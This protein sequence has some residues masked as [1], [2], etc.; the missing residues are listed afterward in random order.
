M[1]AERLHGVLTGHE[2]KTPR[3]GITA[4]HKTMQT[5]LLCSAVACAAL[6]SQ[7]ASARWENLYDTDTL[8][9]ASKLY[10]KN[11]Q[12]T[13]TEDFLAK[14]LP[15]DRQAI[16]NV[17]LL[18]PLVGEHAHPFDYYAY[19]SRK[20]VVV[21]IQSVKFLDDLAIAHTWLLNRN[22]SDQAVFDYVGFLRFGNIKNMPGGRLPT[23]SAALRVP[24]DAL[25]NTWVN[26]VSGKILKSTV[27]FLMAHEAGHVIYAHRP[28]NEITGVQAQNQEKQ[29]DKFAL[30]VMQRIG[31]TPQALAF[32]FMATSWFE[33]MPSDFDSAEEYDAAR[34]QLAT[35]P[36]SSDRLITIAG[37]METHAAEFAKSEP[38]R[39]RA[40]QIVRTAGATIR[41][42]AGMLDDPKIREYQKFRG[43]RVELEVLRNACQ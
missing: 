12:D 29:A 39:Q 22:C 3:I 31:L 38:N 23:P 17:R 30:D 16:G 24:K 37:R 19:P 7:P 34:K 25:N 26:D 14:L 10:S 15:Q 32:F 42:I 9:A 5:L 36:L 35:H 33:P 40:E 20:L 28:Y 43:Q 27:Y 4:V 1:H 21:P 2:M 13:W 6:I 18:L 41:K 8:E 11:L